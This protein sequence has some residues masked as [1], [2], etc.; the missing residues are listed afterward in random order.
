MKLVW[1]VEIRVKGLTDARPKAKQDWVRMRKTR[2]KQIKDF[3][4]FFN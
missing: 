1:G 2:I 4:N 3:I